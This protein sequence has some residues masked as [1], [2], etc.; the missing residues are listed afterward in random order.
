MPDT[1]L[2]ETTREHHTVRELGYKKYWRPVTA[3]IYLLICLVDFMVM[4][5]VYEYN[6]LSSTEILTIIEHVEEDKRTQALEI[7]RSNERVWSPVT[8]QGGAIFH[9]SFGAIIGAAAFTRGMA[10][11]ESIKNGDFPV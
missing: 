4:P 5:I 10:Q 8:T 7:M 9:M 2:K 3:Y 1:E 11:R 6:R